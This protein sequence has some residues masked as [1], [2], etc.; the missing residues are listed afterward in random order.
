ME[1]VAARRGSLVAWIEDHLEEIYAGLAETPI[2]VET[3]HRFFAA[4]EG[5]LAPAASQQDR[6]PRRMGRSPERGR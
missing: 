4:P 6:L 1:F 3:T 2:A 5:A